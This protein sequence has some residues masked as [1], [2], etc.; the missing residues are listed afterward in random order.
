MGQQSEKYSSSQKLILVVSF[1]F[2]IKLFNL[3]IQQVAHHTAT[4][5]VFVMGTLQDTKDVYNVL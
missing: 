3:R 5:R 1:V 4:I 2:A